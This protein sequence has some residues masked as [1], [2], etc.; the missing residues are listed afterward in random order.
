MLKSAP[1][2]G[3][4]Y[5]SLEAANV[6]EIARLVVFDVCRSGW[7]PVRRRDSHEA[8]SRLAGCLWCILLGYRGCLTARVRKSRCALVRG[9]CLEGIDP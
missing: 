3:H 2:L 4:T 6:G 1:L 5:V 8:A 9:F 7:R